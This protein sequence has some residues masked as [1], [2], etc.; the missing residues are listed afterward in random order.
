MLR[1]EDMGQ[2]YRISADTR[3]LNYDKFL[4]NGNV[5]SQ[6]DAEYTSSNTH[7]L[8]VE[9]TVKK[10]MGTQFIQDELKRAEK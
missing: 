3:D 9:E 1:S 7:I 10:I 2:Y 8:T 5:K 4:V 6:A